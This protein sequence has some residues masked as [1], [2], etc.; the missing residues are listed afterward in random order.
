M[1]LFEKIHNWVNICDKRKR[2]KRTLKK[3]LQKGLE[4]LLISFYEREHSVHYYSQNTWSN[5]SFIIETFFFYAFFKSFFKNLRL[6]KSEICVFL[7]EVI[8][9]LFYF[10]GQIMELNKF[11]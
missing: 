9:D 3:I 5:A 8:L 4:Q 7:L 11:R 10:F 1:I 6:E 2:I